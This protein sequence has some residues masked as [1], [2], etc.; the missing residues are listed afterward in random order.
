MDALGEVKAILDAN[1]EGIVVIEGHA[2][3]DGSESFNLKLSENR[4]NT[5]REKLIELGVDA[6]RLEISAMGET[7]P[8]G[9]NSTKE[10]RKESR[11]VIFKGKQR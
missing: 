1:P 9:D 6:A 5:V 3:E 2:S 8:V 10:G 11:R 7:A 4:A